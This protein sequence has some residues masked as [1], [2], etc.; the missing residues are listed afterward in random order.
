MSTNVTKNG[1][2][3]C[4]N[5]QTVYESYKQSCPECGMLNSQLIKEGEV[6]IVETSEQLFNIND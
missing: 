3:R 2:T 5:C 4:G 1:Y 6:S